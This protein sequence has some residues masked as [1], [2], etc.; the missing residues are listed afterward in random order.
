MT[1]KALM[2][3]IAILLLGM[4]SV[5]LIHALDD[6][7]ESALD[8]IGNSVEEIGEEVRDEIDDHTDDR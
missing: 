8:S 1:N 2:S 6:R 5:G 7:D 4:I 3:I